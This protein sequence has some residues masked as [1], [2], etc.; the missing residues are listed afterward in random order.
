[1]AA[2][3]KEGSVKIPKG[4][5]L[6]GRYEIR[7]VLGKGGFSTTYRAYDHQK[8]R[9]VSVK[10]FIAHYL[11]DPDSRALSDE[12]VRKGLRH[13]RNEEE[14]LTFLAGTPGV[15]KLYDSFEENGT[16]FLVKE[17]LEGRTLEEY[18]KSIGGKMPWQSGVSCLYAALETLRP[19]HEKGVVHADISPINLFLCSDG[20]LRIIDWGT[21]LRVGEPNHNDGFSRGQ[22]FNLYYSAP[23]Q[24]RI[25]GILDP[26]TDLF[27]LCA[28][29]YHCV[30][31][32]F[33]R[34]VK[35]RRERDEIVPLQAH[36]ENIPPFLS[37]ILEKGLSL[38]PDARYQS[39]G[40]LIQCL[41]QHFV[42]DPAGGDVLHRVTW[43]EEPADDADKKRGFL[44]R[45]FG[46]QKS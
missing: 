15:L 17:Y 12:D 19:I 31:G 11:D 25:N 42:Y 6:A 4:T 7:D 18:L 3:K 37:D 39:A 10:K 43:K 2:Y 35:E 41:D 26:R 5:W 9:D 27:G 28:T 30:T 29:A 34:N 45:L 14:F 1:M 23:E 44:H 16:F 46:R 13:L 24:L 20:S 22:V 8:E 38:D 33:P 36:D 40:E 32:D 21:A